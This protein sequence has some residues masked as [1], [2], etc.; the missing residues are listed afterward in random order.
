MKKKSWFSTRLQSQ[1]NNINNKEFDNLGDLT[2][3]FI[4]LGEKPAA[5]KHSNQSET[6]EMVASSTSTSTFNVWMMYILSC[7]IIYASG[8]KES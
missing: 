7:L 6:A 3:Y 1:G 5:M 2:F 8:V 4:L